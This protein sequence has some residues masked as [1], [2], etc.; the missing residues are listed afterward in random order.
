LFPELEFKEN[1]PIDLFINP[2]LPL[3]ADRD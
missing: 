3:K 1:A 2:Y